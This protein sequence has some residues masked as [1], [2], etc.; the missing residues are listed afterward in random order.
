MTRRRQRVLAGTTLVSLALLAAGCGTAGK[1]ATSSE[2]SSSAAPSSPGSSSAGE[3]PTDPA[4]EA[5]LD[6]ALSEPAEDSYYPEVGDPSVDA[7]RYDLDL[8]WDPATDTLTGTET[9]TFRSTGTAEEFQLDFAE[10]L[11]ITSLT[12][13][14]AEVDHEHRGKD[15]IVSAPVEEDARHELVVEY[16]GT[17]APVPAPTERS[18]LATTGFTIDAEHQTWTMQE[19]F[20]A[21]TWYAVNDQPADKAL[22]DFTLHVPD[23]WTGVANG[24]KVSDETA[25]GTHTTAFHLAEPAAAYLVTLAFGD[26][27]ETTDVGPNGVPITYWTPRDMEPGSGL[28]YSPEAMAWLETYLGP[29]PFD[30]AGILVVDSESGMETQT[31]ITLGDTEYSMAENTVVH[32]FAHQWYGDQVTPDDWRD[33]WMNEGM[34]MYLQLMWE[35]EQSDVPLDSYL[36]GYAGYESDYR[37]QSGPPADYDPDAFGSSNVYFSG[38][39]FWHALREQVGDEVFFA[40]VKGWPQSQDNRSTDRETLLAYLEDQTGEDLDVLW[41]AWLLGDTSPELP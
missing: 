39:F 33:V 24:A 19:P 18:D 37:A 23:P 34:A 6:L 9:L 27:R 30:T 41:D 8:T 35:A 26:Y 11:E 7:L 17:P 15:L 2:P 29:Y 40:A 20:G 22:Y 1:I 28:R 16:S 21:Y 25:D 12:L 32:E 38:A 36:E 13:D 14:G 4:P 31:M 5:D 10:P 3:D